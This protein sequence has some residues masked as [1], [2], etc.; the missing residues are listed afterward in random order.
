MAALGRLHEFM[1]LEN[2]AGG[3]TRQEA[4]SMIPPLLLDVQPHH[5]VRSALRQGLG[6]RGTSAT[7]LV[8][9]QQGL[10]LRALARRF[11]F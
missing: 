6:L 7:V 8:L 11:E 9:S 2:D 5:S 10:R 4:V 1:K 3:I